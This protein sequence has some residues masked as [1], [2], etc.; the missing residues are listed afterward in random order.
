MDLVVVLPKTL[1]KF[2]SIWV[3]VDRLTKSAHFIP[4]RVDYNMQQLAKVYVKEIV[5]LHRVPLSIILDCGMQFTSKFWGKLHEKLGTQLTFSIAFH[6]QSDGQ[7]ERTI[8]VLEGILRACVI[9]FGGHWD[10]WFE[11]GD[12]KPFGVDLVKDAQDK[13]MYHGDGDYIT[14]WDSVLLDKDLQYEEEP[15]VILDRDIQKLRTKQI[16]SVKVQ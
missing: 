9:H 15:I 8:Q 11:A 3:V 2:D 16:K 13:K 14:K 10:K 12:V 5:R 4:V 1:G 7:P 6:P